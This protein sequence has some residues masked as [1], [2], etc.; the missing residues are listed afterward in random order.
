MRVIDEFHDIYGYYFV[1]F[2][3]ETW[4]IVCVLI[5]GF[6]ILGVVI[7]FLWK[8][9]KK[10]S[11][12][13][14]LLSPWEWAFEALHNLSISKCENREDFKRFYFQLTDVVKEYLHRRY[15]WKLDDKTDDELISYL[16][17]REFD[18]NH[19]RDLRTVMKHALFVKY[20]GQDALL[21]QAE[22]AVDII[23]NIVEKTRAV[24]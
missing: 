16:E 6:L 22:E 19:I 20:A 3:K 7:L 24:E 11:E 18:W 12:I 2:Y 1:P 23:A 21:S 13:R 5:I 8:W 9:W 14:K 15:D 4:F 10:K 17:N